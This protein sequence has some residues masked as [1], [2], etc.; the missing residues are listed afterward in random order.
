[1]E[2]FSEV[3]ATI[4]VGI[5][6][7]KKNE[8]L[9]I[10]QLSKLFRKCQNGVNNYEVT[11]SFEQ[12][13]KIHAELL[14]LKARSSGAEIARS[15][16]AEIARSS[17]AEIARSSGAEIAR[18]SGAEIARSSGTK[19]ARS[20]GA[21][22]SG[23][24]STAFSGAE[25]TRFP[26]AVSTGA[27]AYASLKPPH[28]SSVSVDET[29]LNYIEAIYRNYLLKI[30]KDFDVSLK[31]NSSKKD[32]VEVQFL[33]KKTRLQCP[34]AT[35]KF[36]TL[37]QTVG[38]NL[39][40]K[41][42]ELTHLG[43]GITK[44]DLQAFL[45][46]KF[47]KV[48]VTLKD[49]K[50]YLMGE[51]T[52]VKKAEAA[53]CSNTWQ[54]NKFKSSQLATCA[55]PVSTDSN[56]RPPLPPEYK[57]NSNLAAAGSKLESKD[58]DKTCPICLEEIEDREILKKC[59]HSFCK[60]C[61]KVAFKTK[62]ACPICGEVYGEIRGTQPDDG[63]M[64]SRNLA[65][66]LPGYENCETIEICYTISDGIQGVQHPR[67]GQRY[68]GTTRTAYLPDNS[69]GRRVLRLLQRAFNQ[70]LIFTVG[71]SSTTGRSDVVTWNDIHHKTNT[72]GG[73]SMFGYPDPTYLARV[74]DELKA[75]GIY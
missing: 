14:K 68:F 16:G 52:E 41:T 59:K 39:I 62:S 53:L 21:A 10:L 61:I 2:I 18:S 29:I 8:A 37:Y 49:T 64:S 75:K 7:D 24:E 63:K 38:T 66:R 23:T 4:D 54:D 35:E 72:L 60:E 9:A 27:I 43:R 25:S 65:I 34:G 50:T 15:S 55:V 56:R 51:P 6:K 69:E 47:P 13:D 30:E 17:G 71:T 12:I 20:S 46:K 28:D 5:F 1:M 31:K 42:V 32:I 57:P 74:Q 58:E 45:Q 44:N 22:S 3:S 70:R 67:P 36:I 48:W 40:F 73:P 11:D 26:D 19:S 33:Q